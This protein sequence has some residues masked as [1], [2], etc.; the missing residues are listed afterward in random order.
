MRVA[1]FD[2]D[3][4]DLLAFN[5]PFPGTCLNLEGITESL[6]EL[7]FPNA[8]IKAGGRRVY[9]SIKPGGNVNGV[10][11]VIESQMNDP[12]IM[13]G[14]NGGTINGAMKILITKLQKVSIRRM[15]S[16]HWENS[17]IFGMDPVGAVIQ[18]GTFIQKM[19][20][21][22]WLHSP[23]LSTTMDRLIRNTHIN[24]PHFNTTFIQPVEQHPR[25]LSIMMIKSAK[26]DS[27][28]Y[29]NG[30]ARSLNSSPTVSYTVNAVRSS[31]EIG[32]EKE[33]RRER[34]QQ[35]W[36]KASRRAH[37]HQHKEGD[38]TI[39]MDRYS[40]MVLGYP[41]RNPLYAPYMAD[42][43]SSIGPYPSNPS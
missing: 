6:D 11:N 28:M 13:Q 21:L 31:T 5:H 20:N 29:L 39:E 32:V 38:A 34:F 23:T 8:L 18:Q 7:S 9:N 37:E 10:R 30:L 15:M 25:R 36:V 1:R 41:Y 16:H 14:I 43:S 40:P 3:V 35:S 22:D 24:Y 17:S 12:N 33:I 42:P 26:R 4:E 2:K 27:L 19:D